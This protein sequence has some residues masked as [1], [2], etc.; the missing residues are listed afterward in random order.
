MLDHIVA[1]L[2]V[3]VLHMHHLT[4]P[5]LS[6][7]CMHFHFFYFNGCIKLISWIDHVSTVAQMCV[8]TYL[9]PTKQ[10]YKSQHEG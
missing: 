9:K 8:L 2:F 10:L 6:T 5:Q 7:L 4:N 3:R 1:C